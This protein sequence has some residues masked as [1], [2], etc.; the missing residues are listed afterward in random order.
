MSVEDIIKVIDNAEPYTPK[1]GIPVLF[2]DIETPPI[3]PTLLPAVL[4]DFV[5]ALAEETETPVEMAIACVL[6]VCSTALTGKI[7]VNPKQGWHE[8][9]NTYWFIE[10]PPA[11]LK[12]KVMKECLRPLVAWEKKK[13]IEFFP[14][15]EKANSRRKSQEELIKKQRMEVSK[16]KGSEQRE[17][18][19]EEIDSLE[20]SLEEPMVL[21]QLFCNNVTPEALE[22]YVYEQGGKFA[23]ISDEGGVIETLT[24][25]YTNGKANLDLFLK[26]ID[27]GDVRIGRKDRN[28]IMNPYLTFI[29]C[30]QPR[31]R[32]KMSRNQ[33]LIGNGSLERFLYIIPKSKI[34]YRIHNTKPV[35]ESLKSQYNELITKL[36]D[37][38]M[39]MDFDG[40]EQPHII[41]L[42]TDAYL[43]LQNFQ[44]WLEPQL[45]PSGELYLCQGWAGKIAGYA[46]RIAGLLHIVEYGVQNTEISISTIN[47]SLYIA[48]NLIEHAKVAYKLMNLDE[49]IKHAKQIYD[50]IISEGKMEFTQTEL[51]TAMRHHSKASQTNIAITELEERNI[52]KSIQRNGTGTKKVTTY[53]VNPQ[54]FQPTASVNS[55]IT[56]SSG[57]LPNLP[58]LP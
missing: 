24:G 30:V 20:S 35:P 39:T 32:E 49:K 27:G 12:S 34:G 31:I 41:T 36:L 25:L 46:L 43:L 17:K 37:I 1:W 52:L 21:P 9:V 22:N 56:E 4:R 54:I 38:T 18:L 48:S 50:W 15:I 53:H 26:G 13:R 10:L 58:N 3:P 16:A 28:I 33:A 40:N 5:S 14:I 29:L 2:A 8:P 19:F 6:G 11:N 45:K 7:I 42:S 57:N 44:V 51:T 55:V 23:V 47:N